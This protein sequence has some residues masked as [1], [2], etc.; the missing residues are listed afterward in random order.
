M[1]SLSNRPLCLLLTVLVVLLMSSS[2]GVQCN[3]R[4]ELE[5]SAVRRASTT[6][7]RRHRR[8]PHTTPEDAI[9]R[10][11]ERVKEK[12]LSQLSYSVT[13]AV[14]RVRGSGARTP[15]PQPLIHDLYD[16]GLTAGPARA[17]LPIT[18][19]SQT[20]H[21]VASHYKQARLVV[22]GHKSECS[23]CAADDK[24]SLVY[25]YARRQRQA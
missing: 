23:L 10:Q 21:D 2:A 1:V 24:T 8:R 3:E 5:P 17:G 15:L 18:A 12:I 16:V 11:I 4:L 6:A 9:R 20:T 14:R 22:F 19:A 13:R 7:A 25:C